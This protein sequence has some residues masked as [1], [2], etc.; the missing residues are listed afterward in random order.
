MVLKT[1]LK[2]H[3][4]SLENAWELTH[5]FEKTVKKEKNQTLLFLYK[6]NLRVT[7]LLM[8]AVYLY[9]KIV[10]SKEGMID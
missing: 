1:N 3:W 9:M 7:T 6:L 8:G 5:Y 10:V 4:S 2:T